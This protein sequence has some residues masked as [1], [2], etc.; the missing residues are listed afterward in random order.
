[1]GAR[2]VTLAEYKYR[3][4]PLT[5]AIASVHIKNCLSDAN[6]R[7][8]KRHALITYTEEQH[9][10]GGGT[11]SKNVTGAVKKALNTLLND[12]IVSSPSNGHWA[13]KPTSDETHVKSEDEGGADELP[14]A[15]AVPD[16]SL[17]IDKV[18]GEGP[19][20]V[21][22]YF[23]LA[24]RELAGYRHR[25]Y[26]PCKIGMTAG[27]L[28]ERILTQGVHTSMHKLPCVG[29]AIKTDDAREVERAIHTALDN[30]GCRIEDS[31]GAEWFYT[32]PERLLRWYESYLKISA[33]LGEG[34]EPESMAAGTPESE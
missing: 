34:V 16:A 20:I 8:L 21:Y 17:A 18:F 29:L 31:L 30:A 5:P 32:S 12:D 14:G 9:R 33:E 24:E 10:L 11:P 23:I 22:V 2:E 3:G 19:E 15:Q 26:W 4:V 25:D 1:L 28:V 7:P 13:L 6:G 27:P